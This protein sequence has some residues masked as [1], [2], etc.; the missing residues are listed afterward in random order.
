[1]KNYERQKQQQK[2]GIL[3]LI[4]HFHQILA[5]SRL[6]NQQRMVNFW[7]STFPILSPLSVCFDV[8]LHILFFFV[9][10]LISTSQFT[11][12]LIHVCRVCTFQW[13]HGFFY[14][15]FQFPV[16]ASPATAI[17]LALYNDCYNLHWNKIRLYIEF[18]IKHL[19]FI[20]QMK[21]CFNRFTTI[22]EHG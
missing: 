19:T 21:D 15:G 13:R 11:E 18:A 7:S 1:M 2:S 3:I 16:T 17:S 14:V 10:K 6:K 4:K 20:I 22:L 9:N 12:I 8:L 5:E